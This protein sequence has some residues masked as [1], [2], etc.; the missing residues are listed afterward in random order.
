[1]CYIAKQ[2]TEHT[3]KGNVSLLIL[4]IL[5][6][7]PMH[8]YHADNMDVL[9][10]IKDLLIA[11]FGQLAALFAGVLIFGLLIHI[12]SQ[13]TF[14]SLQKALGIKGIYLV[15]WLGT[16]I[17]ELGHALFC[18][19]FLH[20]ILA[21]KFFE[22]DPVTGTL[23]YVTHTWNNKNPWQVLGNF[24]IGVGPVL[25]GCAAL[26]ALFYF[27]IPGSSEV[28]ETIVVG[29][30]QVD[31]GYAISEYFSIFKE[32]ALSMT[33]AIF[34]LD[35]L[36]HWRFWVFLYLAICVSSNV[37]LSWDDLKLTLRGL[38]CVVLP[39]LLIN[40]IAMLTGSGSDEFF[41]ITASSLGA[42]YS[43]F[44]LALV[45]AVIGFVLIYLLTAIYVKLK[46]NRLLSPF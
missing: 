10:F 21:V 44:I 32:S 27:L 7:P 23:G 40:L 17:H 22:P 20:K 12:V 6:T 39:F 14:K 4:I 35:N 15:A 28:W 30:S 38:G 41:P 29:A 8:S 31:N 13:F 16:P 19:I 18:V 24:F 36:G 25:L 33:G 46:Y 5:D 37:R 26:F 9:V 3:T 2:H 1:M 42:V 11:T 45:L 43:L 34:T